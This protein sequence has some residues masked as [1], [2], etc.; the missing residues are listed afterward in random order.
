VSKAA[1][2]VTNLLGEGKNRGRSVTVANLSNHRQSKDIFDMRRA[3]STQMHDLNKD[4]DGIIQMTEDVA[5]SYGDAI[6]SAISDH[7]VDV[8]RR[9][10]VGHIDF[11]FLMKIAAGSEHGSKAYRDILQEPEYRIPPS[12]SFLESRRSLSNRDVETP[13]ERSSTSSRKVSQTLRPDRHSLFGS[14]H[15]DRNPISMSHGTDLESD[16][17]RDISS[18]SVSKPSV[19]VVEDI[20]DNRSRGRDIDSVLSDAS[21]SSEKVSPES[22]PPRTRQAR[23]M[24]DLPPKF[25]EL[26]LR[27]GMDP[28]LFPKSRVHNGSRERNLH[29]RA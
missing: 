18:S 29:N 27:E 5:M 24:S 8:V 13:P 23:A 19:H 28:S 2:F 7:H 12:S 21:D 22:P 26:H 11:D 9:P 20:N 15:R 4:I 25:A 16:P 1:N 3:H 14:G 6:R 17:P 10:T